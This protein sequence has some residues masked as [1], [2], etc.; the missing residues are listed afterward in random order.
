MDSCSPD[1]QF[2]FFVLLKQGGFPLKAT[3]QRTWAPLTPLGE[4]GVLNVGEPTQGCAFF[5]P[6]AELEEVFQ[7]SAKALKKGGRLFSY[8]R[9]GDFG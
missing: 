8:E 5:P 3:K 6:S 9:L 1:S 7:E 2:S 4:G